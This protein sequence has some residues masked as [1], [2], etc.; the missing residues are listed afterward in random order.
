MH[1]TKNEKSRK[2]VIRLTAIPK[3]ASTVVLVDEEYN[4]F[5]TKRPKT[6][7]FL[8]GF[9]VF[10]G[11]GME[12]EDVV[13]QDKYFIGNPANDALHK[14]HY[15]AAARELFEEVGILLGET[16]NG[17]AVTLPEAHR[18]KLRQQL[19]QNKLTFGQLLIH[20]KLLFNFDRLHYFGQLITPEGLPIRFDTK[21]F[22][23][24]L[25]KKQLPK[26]YKQEIEEAFWVSA[27]EGLHLSK[28]NEILLAPPTL[29]VLESII[30]Y[31]KGKKLTIE[32]DRVHYLTERFL[33]SKK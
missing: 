12:P 8:G 15:I 24:K 11:G 18:E 13:V 3:P 5:L 1:I 2:G 25:P 21:F 4:V 26:P 29:V 28:N 14:G 6:M 16:K 19:L 32:N 31:K 33:S 9:Y 10:P 20:E 17:V 7:K 22:L 30:N 23:A 27:E